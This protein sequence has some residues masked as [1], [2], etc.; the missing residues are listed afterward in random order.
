M[1]TI[2]AGKIDT[3]YQSRYKLSV[4]IE[5]SAYEPESVTTIDELLAEVD[6]LIYE[7]KKNKKKS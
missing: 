4:G 1:I 5:I 6:R 3:S 2:Q 7:H